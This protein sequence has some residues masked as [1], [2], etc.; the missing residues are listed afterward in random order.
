MSNINQALAASLASYTALKS[1]ENI[2]EKI[3]N[4]QLISTIFNEQSHFGAVSYY[5]ENDKTLMMAFRGSVTYKDWL[6]N[7]PQILT[8]TLL[9]SPIETLA[10]Q[11]AKQYAD[12][13]LKECNK[14]DI[15]I[16]KVLTVGHS[17]G[18]RE[19]MA[20]LMH[21]QDQ[22]IE[23]QCRALT[24]NAAPLKYKGQNQ[25]DH[26]NLRLSGGTKFST[27][28]V[29]SVGG[30]LG[31][32]FTIKTEKV[33]NFVAAHSLLNFEHIQRE[34][35]KFTSDHLDIVFEYIKS[36]QTYDQYSIL[37]HGLHNEISILNVQSR[38]EFI[39][40]YVTPQLEHLNLYIE[41]K[42]E[43]ETGQL[44]L[45]LSSKDSMYKYDAYLSDDHDL[46]ISKYPSNRLNNEEQISY[47]FLKEEIIQNQISL[48][49]NLNY[50]IQSHESSLTEIQG[51]T[52]AN[53][54]KEK[55]GFNYD[56]SIFPDLQDIPTYPKGHVVHQYQSNL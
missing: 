14:N 28:L 6:I 52:K 11:H 22:N 19:A 39:Q 42:T 34:N 31:S 38:E 2:P 26:V 49:M 48:D 53:D 5:N 18:G 15:R 8:E 50:T 30:H 13:L 54:I 3:N 1:A 45:S 35:P 25:Y 16:E 41:S 33:K 17:K 37:E 29:A 9:G 10:D 4:F 47:I 43:L 20:V 23:L 51:A 7:N 55:L 27:D 32:N 21:I 12:S 24:F 56:S 44:Q 36:G 40:R 46:I